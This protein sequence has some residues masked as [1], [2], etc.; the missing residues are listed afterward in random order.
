MAVAIFFTPTPMSAEQYRECVR[1]LEAAG[2][3]A[4]AGRLLHVCFESGGELRVLDVWDSVESC[5]EFGRALL[6]ILDDL[7][8]S[9]G[10]SVVGDVLNIIQG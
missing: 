10:A 5:E 8:V 3:G 6:P 2:A 9:P 1:R 4:P 7:G